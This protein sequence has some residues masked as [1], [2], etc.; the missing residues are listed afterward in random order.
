[1]NVET[2]VHHR[3]RWF[4]PIGLVLVAGLLAF[5]VGCSKDAPPGA[6]SSTGSTFQQAVDKEASAGTPQTGGQLN[7]GLA[8]ET[9]GWNPY[10]G[11]WAGSAYIVANAI[12]DPLAGIDPQGDAKPY[13][14]E[15]F[16][17][18]ADFTEW[19]IK[20]RP[21]INFHNG[22]KLDAEAVRTNLQT[23]R[24][25]GLTK[26]VFETVTGLT[27]VDDLTL[28]VTMSKPWSTFP[29]TLAAQPGYMAAP[30]QLADTANGQSNP[31]GTGPF[32]FNSWTR[33]STLKVRKNPTYWQKDRPYLDAIEFKVLTDIQ[34]R[35]AALDSGAVD[36]IEIGLPEPLLRYQERAQ[37]GEF[38]MFTDTDT[39]TDE[40]I[41]ALNTTKPPFN[42]PIAR[43]A[44]ATGLDQ[45]DLSETSYKG[46]FPAAW[47]PFKENSPN[48]LSPEAAGYPKYDPERAKQ[49]VQQYK[50]NHPGEELKFTALIP[51]DP[52][53]SAIAQALQQRAKEFGVTVDL[54]AVEQT[55]LITRVLG[56]DYQAS[57]FVLFS[58]PSLD[59]GYV[60]IATEPAAQG[61]SLNFTRYL[62]PNIKKAM[63]DARSTADKGKQAEAYKTVQKEMAKDLDKIFL[64][65]NVGS[66]VYR[67]NVH[68]VRATTFPGTNIPAYAGF[69]TTPFS[70]STWKDQNAGAAK[71]K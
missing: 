10:I 57:G 49:L 28:S 68:G 7:F 51:P 25:S 44:I 17:P 30:S 55:T 4:G 31:V 71:A 64:V 47:G 20:L 16:T 14:A 60:F 24:D 59:R 40:T 45:R 56:G 38:Q 23:G 66:I 2:R 3:S 18:N 36:A 6:D 15:S 27:V 65:H 52:Q 37:A 11:Q 70:T 35:G 69:S 29:I 33:D 21:G 53:Y 5:A 46:A 26:P 39:D 62:N 43:E 58:T 22:A 42:D 50:T 12:F 54:A 34:G 13:L 63:D 9:S 67:N 19:K 8:A 1:M 48:Y 41:I 61:L 32:V